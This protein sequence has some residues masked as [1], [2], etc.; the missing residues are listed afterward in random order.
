MNWQNLFKEGHV[1]KGDMLVIK[2]RTKEIQVEVQADASVKFGEEI[3]KRPSQIWSKHFKESRKISW[4]DAVY[5]NQQTI[6]S[7]RASNPVSRKYYAYT[8]YYA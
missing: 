5:C 3:F 7:L 2:G 1:K 6:A 8:K 4:V